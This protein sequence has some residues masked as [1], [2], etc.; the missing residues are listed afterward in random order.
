MNSRPLCAMSSDPNDFSALTPGHFLI[1]APLLAIPESDLSDVKSSRLK[2]WSLVQQ[3]V[4]HFW[5]RWCAEYLTTL[6]QRAKW[7]RASPNLKCGDLVL[8]KNEQLP[9]N[10]W[11]IGRIALIYPGSDKKVR[12]ATIHT[13]AGDFKR[14]VTKLCLIPNHD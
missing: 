13:A 4:Q 1:G 14:A 9:P 6:Q 2:R 12:V 5:K 3:T 8:I 11:K 10:Q 7:F